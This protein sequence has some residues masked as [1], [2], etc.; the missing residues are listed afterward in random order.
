[1][2]AIRPFACMLTVGVALLIFG[3]PGSAGNSSGLIAR[4]SFRGLPWR[5]VGDDSADGSYCITLEVRTSSGWDGP[6]G[7]GSIKRRD[8]GRAISI[9]ARAGP[10]RP[11]FAYGPV[12]ATARVVYIRLSNGHVLRSRTI[13]PPRGFT[14]WIGFYVTELP[15]PAWPTHLRALDRTG[16]IVAQ[17]TFPRPSVVRSAFPC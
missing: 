5:L 11:N 12:V 7:C 15:C 6:G 9:V 2:P 1:M 4:G 8:V 13:A 3:A 10:P 14:P 16:R 17:I